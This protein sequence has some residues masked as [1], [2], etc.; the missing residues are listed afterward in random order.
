MN[1]AGRFVNQN[2]LSRGWAISM[3]WARAQFPT[4]VLCLAVLTTALS[5]VYA[6][7]ANRGFNSAIQQTLAERDRLHVQWGQLLLEKSTW[8]VQ[9]RVQKIAEE[10]LSMI[11]PDS[12]SVTIISSN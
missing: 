1:A 12:K 6:T 5:M 10:K 9:A 7:N 4:M 11:I 2:V 3:F 8:V